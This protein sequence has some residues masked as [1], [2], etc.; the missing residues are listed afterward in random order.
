MRWSRKAAAGTATAILAL[1][2]VGWLLWPAALGGRTTYVT[3][4]GVSMAPSFHTGDLALMRPAPSYHVGQVVAYHSSLLHTVVMHR[5]VAI[6]GGHYVF[7][8]DNNSWRDPQPPT[9][10]QL[11]G[12]LA[13]RIPHGGFWLERA[14]SPAVLG[15]VAFVLLASGGTVAQTRRTRRRR[16]VSRHAATPTR[17]LEPMSSLPP[18]L[19]TAATA[20][21][22]VGLL[23]AALGVLAW[24][25]PPTVAAT[26]TTSPTR[27]MSFS[28]TAAVPKTAAYD[29]TTV[30]SPDPVFRKLANRVEVHY[31]YRGEPGRISVEAALS[32]VSGW[33]STISLAATTAFTSNTYDGTVRLHLNALEARAQRAARVIGIPAGDVSVAVKPIVQTGTASFAP[34]L[35][36]TLTPLQ[37]SFAGDPKKLT[38]V[39]TTSASHRG[40]F[41]RRL[42]LAGHA[43][44]VSLARLL[45]IGVLLL[46]L[47]AG[48]LLFLFGRGLAPNT[49]GASIRRRY[50]DL[51]VQVA[52][53]PTPPGRPVVDV[54]NFTTLARLAER[55]GLLVLHWSR[56]GIETFVVQDDATTY[57]YRTGFGDLSAP[58]PNMDV[59]PARC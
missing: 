22:A 57:R 10:D 32:A 40:T 4:H 39:D 17:R 18:Q 35:P 29:G 42:G 13:L 25:R 55:Y 5:I 14:T 2:A 53:M 3:T 27:S 37:L 11:I 46:A 15:V 7:K 36:L 16:K 47:L 38:V 24:T 21:A 12:K 41:A 20:T 33:H 43:I 52:P 56:S 34:T 58:A 1:A 9:R 19:R 48:A 28:Y 44:T 45:S 6:K 49:E 30:T 26:I 50:P 54:A 31:A 23:G 59:L 51:L 8:G